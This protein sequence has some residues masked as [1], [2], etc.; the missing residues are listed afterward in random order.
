MSHITVVPVL[1]MNKMDRFNKFPIYIRAT[2]DRK[3]IFLTT[4]ES[5]KA[6]EWDKKSS[7]IRNAAERSMVA[8]GNIRRKITRLK[9]GILK[10]ELNEV[11]LTLADLKLIHQGEDLLPTDF[12]EYSESRIEKFLGV[13]N[14][15]STNQMTSEIAKL[16][17]FKTHLNFSE[18]IGQ[19]LSEYDLWLRKRGNL[20]NTVWKT[21]KFIKKMINDAGRDK[22]FNK[23]DYPFGKGDNLYHISYKQNIPVYL[24]MA[25]IDRVVDKLSDMSPLRQGIGWSFVLSAY[26]GLRYSDAST[27][28]FDKHIVAGRLILETRKGKAPVSIKVHTRLAKAIEMARLYKPSES[29]QVANRYLK[30]IMATCEIQKDVS[31]HTSRHSFAVECANLGIP[32][33]VVKRLLGHSSI[34]HTAIYY[35]ITDV[36]LDR[37]M[38]NWDKN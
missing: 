3:S 29:N 9:D 10:A 23:R 27:F 22:K 6:H 36:T 8:N 30:Q 28:D 15:A 19:F 1:K 32:I 4:G 21:M 34:T 12:Y 13:Y 11:Q 5:V 31:F 18:V 24:T 14:I 17:E 16:R 25:E 7:S 35:K 2:L 20:H 33:E 38:D 26:S 37:H